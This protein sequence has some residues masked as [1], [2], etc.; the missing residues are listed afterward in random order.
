ME[1]QGGPGPGIY[2]C[3]PSMH[4]VPEHGRAEGDGVPLEHEIGMSRGGRWMKCK[5]ASP[6]RYARLTP[7]QDRTGD[8]QRVGLTS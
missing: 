1:R 4:A 5:R 3:M 8:L 6:S 7:G 2:G